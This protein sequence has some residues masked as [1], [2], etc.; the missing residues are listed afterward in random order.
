M[1][2]VHL[3]ASGLLVSVVFFLGRVVRFEER[4][5]W[6]KRVDGVS[7]TIAWSQI[8]IPGL[9]PKAKRKRN[10]IEKSSGGKVSA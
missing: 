9:P 1:L 4:M 6:K 7:G 2:H 5:S 3:Q 8:G 10:S